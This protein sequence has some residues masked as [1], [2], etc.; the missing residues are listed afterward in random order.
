MASVRIGMVGSGFMAHT[1]AEVVAR[2]A[3]GGALVAI[4]EGSR[5]PDLAR[6]YGVA[7]EPTLARLLAR[8]D[9]D[10]VVLAG[11]ETMRLAQTQAAAAAGKH[12][13]AEKPMATSVAECDAMIAACDAAGVRLMIVQTQRF[14]GVHQRAKRLIT[15]GQI[16]AVRQLR[17]W[18]LF[19]E[20]W[21][22]PVVG[23]RPWYA[24][25]DAGIFMSQ[26]VHNFDLMRWLAGSE[27]RR[28]FANV[29]SHGAH[30]LPNLSTVAIVEFASGAVGQ[31]WTSLELP[32]G[33]FPD[34]QFR[35][36]V[37]GE[38]G[39]LDF[40]G[41]THLDLSSPATNHEWQR[42]WTQPPLDPMDPLDPV[43][44]ESFTGQVQDFLDCIRQDRPPIVTG[45]DGRAA[46]EL[47][48]AA[49][50]SGR[51]GQPVDLPLA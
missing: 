15:E 50:L 29:G 31:L 28:V 7:H 32:G 26:C 20:S 14:R 19:P 48:Q 4:A 38:R 8:D 44:L 34:S 49:L 18:S 41:Y 30:G 6:R 17:L 33:T 47:C 24:D 22:V 46:V 43:R 12:V 10:A 39:L 11:P 3:Q 35:S 16:G 2:Y 21:T 25:P 1:Y 5:A 40:D 51:T 13:L 9:L 37:V 42:V 36:Q 27:A 45:T 23:Q